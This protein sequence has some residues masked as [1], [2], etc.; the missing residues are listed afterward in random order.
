[1]HGDCACCA[2]CTCCACYAA[3]VWQDQSMTTLCKHSIFTVSCWRT[4]QTCTWR[5]CLLC[6][7]HPAGLCLPRRACLPRG[8]QRVQAQHAA[9]HLCRGPGKLSSEGGLVSGCAIT[10]GWHAL[11]YLEAACRQVNMSSLVVHCFHAVGSTLKPRAGQSQVVS[12]ALS[13]CMTL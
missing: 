2:C 11:P 12:L 8:L 9:A 6:R 3:W 4:Y 5:L 10:A 13:S 7:L 1:M